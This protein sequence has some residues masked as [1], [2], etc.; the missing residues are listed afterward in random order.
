MQNQDII[1]IFNNGNIERTKDDNAY[2][3]ITN[4]EGSKSIKIARTNVTKSNPTGDSQIGE[5]KTVPLET[6]GHD[7][8]P[9]GTKFTYLQIQDYGAATQFFEFA[10]DNTKVEFGQDTL[11]FS[12]GYST[13]IVSTNHSENESSSAV[14]A[15][16]YVDVSQPGSASRHFI[17]NAT[18]QERVHSHTLGS[19]PGP[20]GFS[21]FPKNGTWVSELELN[22]GDR[23][24]YDSNIK[25]VYQY[26]PKVG[27][28]RY[29]NQTSTYTGKTKK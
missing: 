5:A 18:R 24:N 29:T 6:E 8:V 1:K 2:D 7:D 12:D 26:T 28:F 16:G 3:T 11:N 19:E 10:A 14:K 25:N 15:I 4:E 23:K 20:A 27:Y 22:R 13:N 21:S 9:G 17:S